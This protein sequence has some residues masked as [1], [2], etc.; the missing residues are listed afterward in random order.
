MSNSKIVATWGTFDG[1]LHPGHLAF[2]KKC[3]S[4][5]NVVVFVSPDTYITKTKS[6]HPIFTQ[7]IRQDNLLKSGFVKRTI[8]GLEDEDLNTQ[9]ILNLK[10][11][12]YCF[13]DH[14]KPWDL[15]LAEKLIKIGTQL[16]HTHRFKADK[17]STTALYFAEYAKNKRHS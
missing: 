11:D 3:A 5:G 13:G 9:A 17:Y 8:S 1:E 7:A 6:R 16:V 4:Y 12:V 10:P 2:L 15:Q 14:N